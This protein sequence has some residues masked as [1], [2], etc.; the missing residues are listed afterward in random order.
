MTIFGENF[1]KIFNL[2]K[3]IQVNKAQNLENT[4]SVKATE[5]INKDKK[6]SERK[7]IPEC[8]FC[9]QR[10]TDYCNKCL[11]VQQIYV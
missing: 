9:P 1:F 7:S 2:N 4:A 6:D 10:N 3:D 5:N 11:R 8:S